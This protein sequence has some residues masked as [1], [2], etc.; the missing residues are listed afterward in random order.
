MRYIKYEIENIFSD[1][2]YSKSNALGCRLPIELASVDWSTA[3]GLCRAAEAVHN[4][5]PVLIP[6][7][8]FDI[9]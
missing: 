5:T 9:E 3:K 2:K 8:T 4:S 1:L 6:R 7:G